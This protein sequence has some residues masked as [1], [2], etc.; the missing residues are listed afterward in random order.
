MTKPRLMGKTPD[1]SDV[2]TLVLNQEGVVAQPAVRRYA[3]VEYGVKDITTPVHGGDPV[4]RIQITH[5]E[6]VDAD[7][8]RLLD[9]TFTNRTGQAKRPSPE[10]IQDTPLDLSQLAGVT[11]E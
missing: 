4:A 3:V 11:P 8:E 10:E 1:S 2:N 7:G 6:D 9:K 5:W